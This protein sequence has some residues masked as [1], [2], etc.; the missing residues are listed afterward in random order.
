MCII[1][2]CNRVSHLSDQ[3]SI[4]VF[5]FPHTVLLEFGKFYFKI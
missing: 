2:G 5:Y 4:H 3:G 1:K